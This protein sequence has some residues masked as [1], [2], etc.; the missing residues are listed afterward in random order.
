MDVGAP[1]RLASISIGLRSFG[2]SSEY[3]VLSQGYP[4]ASTKYRPIHKPAELIVVIV[5]VSGLILFRRKLFL[6]LAGKSELDV[7]AESDIGWILTDLVA[8]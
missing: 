2:F 1:D 8:S 5:F 3:L 4:T 7:D 6:Q